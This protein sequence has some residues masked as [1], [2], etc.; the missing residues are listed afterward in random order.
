MFSRK[1]EEMMDYYSVEMKAA[2]TTTAA[3]MVRLMDCLLA[4]SLVEKMAEMLVRMTDCLS[5]ASLAVRMADTKVRM[6]DD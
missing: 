1:T 4:A 5:D 3:M 2:Q 6:M